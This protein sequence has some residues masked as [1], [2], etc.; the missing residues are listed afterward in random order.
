MTETHRDLKEALL[1]WRQLQKIDT[2]FA[3]LTIRLRVERK[4]IGRLGGLLNKEEMDLKKLESAS[5]RSLFHKILGDKEKQIEKERQQYLQ[6]ALKYNELSKSIELGI[7][8]QIE[9]FNAQRQ[10]SK[11]TLSIYKMNDRYVHAFDSKSRSQR[12]FAISRISSV[13]LTT[14]KYS[15]PKNYQPSEWV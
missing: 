5:I 2:H 12:T 10:F 6:T 4:E 9:Y 13:E 15:I 11:R 3:A 1:E 8:I 14:Q 7:S